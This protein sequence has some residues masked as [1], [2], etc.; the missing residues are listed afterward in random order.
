MRVPIE[1]LYS[2]RFRFNRFPMEL[3]FSIFFFGET[4]N[5]PDRNH[6]Q[7]KRYPHLMHKDSKISVNDCHKLSRETFVKKVG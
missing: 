5:K 1:I 2:N 3:F 7:A 6:S 4:N